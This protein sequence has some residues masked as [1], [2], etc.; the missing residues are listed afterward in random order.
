MKFIGKNPEYWDIEPDKIQ[1]V[2][3]TKYTGD[4]GFLKLRNKK[5]KC[6]LYYKHLFRKTEANP[7]P[8]DEENEKLIKTWLYGPEPDAKKAYEI[9][10]QKE[11]DFQANHPIRKGVKVRFIKE[12]EAG[13]YEGRIFRCQSE[14]KW[15]TMLSGCVCIH[16]VFSLTQVY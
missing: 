3:A 16:R 10:K 11:K 9:L 7:D 8:E 12:V 6:R 14:P 15:T 2:Q 1:V 13:K 5:G 4:Q